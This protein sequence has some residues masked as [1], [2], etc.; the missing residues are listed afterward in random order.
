M[1][2]TFTGW[3]SEVE[4]SAFSMS[5]CSARMLNTSS[6]CHG[7]TSVKPSL[8]SPRIAPPTVMTPREPVG[9]VRSGQND[10]SRISTTNPIRPSRSSAG[11]F[12]VSPAGEVFE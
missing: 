4:P 12:R 5:A 7:A 8:C 10:I 1:R 9:T 3:V 2:L 6:F 11:P